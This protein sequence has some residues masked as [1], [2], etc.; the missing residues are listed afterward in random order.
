ME[1]LTKELTC[2]LEHRG[3][4]EV[5]YKGGPGFG[6]GHAR[7][8]IM[9][10]AAGHQPLVSKATGAA[11][12]HNG[13]IYNHAKLRARTAKE[14]AAAGKPLYEFQTG[15]DS[16]AVLPFFEDL[17]EGVIS[18]LDGMFTVIAV[19]A[20]GEQVVVGR[21]PCGIK[22]LYRG[23]N[24][25]GRVIFASELKCLVGQVLSPLPLLPIRQ[26]IPSQVDC[27]C[28]LA[29]HVHARRFDVG[30]RPLLGAGGVRVVMLQPWSWTC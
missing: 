9:D 25:D 29:E 24:T 13:E 4:D 11:V 8:S 6:L 23:W 15:S 5:G 22:P 1:K 20:D 26:C 18:Q 7:L 30:L 16:E 28:P 3:P 19:S 2:L 21:D 12:I 17:G 10:P 27:I 14:R